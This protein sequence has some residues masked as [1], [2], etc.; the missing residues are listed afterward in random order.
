[1]RD[2]KGVRLN[3]HLSMGQAAARSARIVCA[4]VSMFST[5]CASVRSAGAVRSVRSMLRALPAVLALSTVVPGSVGA[6]LA[7]EARFPTSQQAAPQM[8]VPNFAE[9]VKRY[10]PAV[11]NIS[12]THEVT[13]MGVQLPPGIAPGNPLA[14]FLARRVIGN[15]EEVSLGSGFIIGSDGYILTNRHVVGD[16]D[17]VDVKLTD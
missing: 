3:K 11:V 6:A 9:L 1:M 8:T 7:D 16:A 4:G 10:G 5:V 2:R 13:Q 14:P 12:V 17:T 15:R